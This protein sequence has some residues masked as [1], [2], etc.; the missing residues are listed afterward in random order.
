MAF[1]ER[2]DVLPLIGGILFDAS[3]IYRE[4]LFEGGLIRMTIE[5]VLFFVLKAC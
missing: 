5:F 1:W 3:S 2:S 4:V